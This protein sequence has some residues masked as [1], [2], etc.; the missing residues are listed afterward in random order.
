M[1]N[2]DRIDTIMEG[3]TAVWKR[4]PDLRLCQLL[5]NISTAA[6]EKPYNDLLDDELLETEKRIDDLFYFEDDDLLEELEK[7]KRQ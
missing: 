1:R 4:Y 5:H 3:L 6:T 7:Y 2:P